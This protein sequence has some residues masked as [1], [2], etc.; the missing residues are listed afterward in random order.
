MKKEEDGNNFSSKMDHV[1]THP[2]FGIGIFFLIMLFLF[3]AI[4]S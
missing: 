2:V 1:L 4:F 3:Q